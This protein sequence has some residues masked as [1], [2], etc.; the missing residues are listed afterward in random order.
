M[1]FIILKKS[2]RQLHSLWEVT[3][4]MRHVP[5]LMVLTLVCQVGKVRVRVHEVRGLV[6][7]GPG[8]E[9][10]DLRWLL[11]AHDVL[12]VIGRGHH[13]PLLLSLVCRTWRKMYFG[14]YWKCYKFKFW[15]WSKALVHKPRKREE[16]LSIFGISISKEWQGLSWLRKA[17]ILYF[18]KGRPTNIIERTYSIRECFIAKKESVPIVWHWKRY[19]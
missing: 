9:G 15:A 4:F 2:R 7:L 11:E 12:L 16:Y 8:E 10:R 19:S 3:E 5:G 18:V 1:Y 13:G 17:N 14:K 6:D